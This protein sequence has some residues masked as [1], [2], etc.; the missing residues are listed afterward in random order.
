MGFFSSTGRRTA[1][2]RGWDHEGQRAF[3]TGSRV[4]GTPKSGSDLDV[5]MLL[6]PGDFEIAAKFVRDKGLIGGSAQNE[7]GLMY[8]GVSFSVQAGPFNL[9]V[10]KDPAL[11]QTW[12]E[13]TRELQSIAPVSRDE[14]VEVFTALR[15][16]AGFV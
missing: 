4:Y 5:V 7:T 12:V 6:S 1:N 2:T 10:T 14:A 9:I 11:Y 15:E 13:G 3:L 16:Q 8:G